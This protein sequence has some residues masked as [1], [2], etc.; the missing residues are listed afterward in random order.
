MC[1]QESQ[2]DAA[3]RVK[4]S[5]VGTACSMAPKARSQGDSSITDDSK[6]ADSG[7]APQ[8]TTSSQA[9]PA[10]QPRS[11]PAGAG[12][13]EDGH[14]AAFIGMQGTAVRRPLLLAVCS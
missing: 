4:V 5:K 10:S 12:T 2:I 7:S 14:G 6:R 8:S 11:D 1:V 3:A 13:G 9:V